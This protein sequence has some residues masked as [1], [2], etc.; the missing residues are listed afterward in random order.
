LGEEWVSGIDKNIKMFHPPFD[1]IV[2]DEMMGEYSKGI[3]RPWSKWDELEY[4]S[5]LFAFRSMPKVDVPL[6]S[7]FEFFNQEGRDE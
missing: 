7:E 5:A 4:K 3:V 6:I 2:L 1:N